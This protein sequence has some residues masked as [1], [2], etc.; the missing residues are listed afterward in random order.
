LYW[1]DKH[2][3]KAFLFERRE[4]HGLGFASHTPDRRD[5]QSIK[6]ALGRRGKPE[7]E[8]RGLQR[9]NRAFKG[10]RG[11]KVTLWR[12]A[13]KTQ[14]DWCALNERKNKRPE[15]GTHRKMRAGGRS[16]RR[17]G[18]VG[19]EGK[20]SKRLWRPREF[21][22]VYVTQARGGQGALPHFCLAENRVELIK[23]KKTGGIR[24]EKE[25]D[26]TESPS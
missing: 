19:E 21:A 9:K 20:R 3:G 22:H 26:Q 16:Q 7:S 13:R 8:R 23:R 1:H 4:S 6:N 10:L 15:R 5:R 11:G 2:E 12:C 17:M 24:R 25:R 14:G 18:A